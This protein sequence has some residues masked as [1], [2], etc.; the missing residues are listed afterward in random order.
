MSQFIMEN[1]YNVNSS[2]FQCGICLQDN[3]ITD[4][5]TDY[6]EYMGTPAQPA[7]LGRLARRG[8]AEV[9]AK[10]AVP[11]HGSWVEKSR[12]NYMMSP[13]QLDTCAQH[14]KMSR[15]EFEEYNC[16]PYLCPNTGCMEKLYYIP[17]VKLFKEPGEQ[18][19]ICRNGH[20]LT[21]EKYEQYL[22]GPR[23]CPVKYCTESLIKNPNSDK[24]W[25][26]IVSMCSNGHMACD[27]CYMKLTN[28]TLSPKC[29]MCRENMSEKY[30]NFI[31][32]KGPKSGPDQVVLSLFKKQ[33]REIY[34]T[35]WRKNKLS[36]L[37]KAMALNVCNKRWFEECS[38]DRVKMS[39]EAIYQKY[40]VDTAYH[41]TFS[42]EVADLRKIVANEV[43]KLEVDVQIMATKAILEFEERWREILN[44]QMKKIPCTMDSFDEIYRVSHLITQFCLENTSDPHRGVTEAPH[45]KSNIERLEI[46]EEV[47]GT[48]RSWLKRHYWKESLLK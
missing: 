40:N 19:Q 46:I 13:M 5:P 12:T 42:D 41:R 28:N 29:P 37:M 2:K 22:I 10:A 45:M 34:N 1:M 4:D 47:L 20:T 25:D 11:A 16:S 36:N 43:C 14:H 26:R 7:V 21:T 44:I 6:S 9:E 18:F 33:P 38:I 39:L 32:T 8:V 48:F 23:R 30:T 31:P 27:K 15:K 24:A 3:G 35:V 17:D